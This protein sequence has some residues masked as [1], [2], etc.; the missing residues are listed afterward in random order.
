MLEKHIPELYALEQHS[1]EDTGSKSHVD[2]RYEKITLWRDYK[3]KCREI[4]A[5][6]PVYSEQSNLW[7]AL[8]QRSFNFLMNPKIKNSDEP[9]QTKRRYATV[10]D[11][12]WST[13]LS[14]H[15]S[16]GALN[17]V[18]E[19]TNQRLFRKRRNLW[20]IDRETHMIALTGVNTYRMN[21]FTQR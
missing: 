12:E 2:T 14:N 20:K 11:P 13:I 9:S 19:C 21:K 4:P 10:S 8:Q 17:P 5:L 6:E 3:R 7:P 1:E 16:I 18:L 15:Y